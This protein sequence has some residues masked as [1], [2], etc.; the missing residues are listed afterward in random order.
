[1]KP[2]VPKPAEAPAE[3]AAAQ[4]KVAEAPEPPVVEPAQNT[5]DALPKAPFPY[6]SPQ[7]APLLQVPAHGDA[8]T[9][10]PAAAPAPAQPQA[11]PDD[12]PT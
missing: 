6:A 9:A 7:P 10:P 5:V 11:A 8:P 3:A 12:A 4:N 1:M 2:P